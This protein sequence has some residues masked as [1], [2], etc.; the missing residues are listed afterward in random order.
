MFRKMS[1]SE[2]DREPVPEDAPGT[3]VKKKRV[4]HYRRDWED[5]A[6]FSWIRKV[7]GNMFAVECTLRQNG[8]TVNVAHGGRSDLVQH[9]KTECHQMAARAACSKTMSSFF[10]LRLNLLEL[11]DR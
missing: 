2:S 7:P 11:M 10:Y 8:K 3:P 1:S 9:M 4:C 6:E 5:Q